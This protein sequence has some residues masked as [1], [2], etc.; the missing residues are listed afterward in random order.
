LYQGLGGA[1]NKNNY[2]NF[3]SFGNNGGIGR[4]GNT[5][6]EPT[7]A[8]GGGGGAGSKGSDFSY[9]TGGGNGGRGKDFVSYFGTNVGHY[10]FFAGGGGGNT[11][12]ITGNRGYGNGGLGLYGGG[13]NGG[14]DGTLEYSADNGLVNTGGGGG[15]GKYDG[16]TSGTLNGGAGGSGYVII[17]YRRYQ[18]QSSSL[19]LVTVKQIPNEIIVSGTTSTTIGSTDRCIIFPYTSDTTGSGQT[20]YTFTTT[21]QL[22]CDILMVAGGGAGGKDTGGGGGGGAVLYGKS[23]NIP[24]GTY[25]IK[26]GK[27]AIAGDVRGKTTEGFG[28]TLLGGGSGTNTTWGDG[29]TVILANSG[30]SGAGGHSAYS[31]STNYAG[32]SIGVSV[33][34]TMLSSATLY[35]GNVGGSGITQGP[36]TRQP[37]SSGGGGGAGSAGDIGTDS[38]TKRGYGGA[39]IFV[40]ILDQVYLWGAGGGGGAYQAPAGDGGLGGGGRGETYAAPVSFGTNGDVGAY[41]Y[42]YS[43]SPINAGNGTGSGGGGAAQGSSVGGS[44]GSGIVIIRYRRVTVNAGYN[45]VNDGGEFKVK[46][47]IDGIDYMRITRDGG[48]IYN[49]TGTPVW[50]TVSDRR[51]KEGIEVASYDRCFESIGGIELYRYS[52]KEGINEL[53]RDKRQ[54]GY[55]AQEVR[56]VLPKAVGEGGEGIL[57]I[58]ITQINYTLYG[59]VKRLMEKYKEK[60]ARLERLE[61]LVGGIG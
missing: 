24:I 7:H 51:I 26:V 32:G 54:L 13:G 30:G 37:V 60:M 41:G 55:I 28:A 36:V 35:S 31:S 1:S 38:G 49:G 2:I 12:F 22:N 29:T 58:D 59:A 33:K 27:G 45:I 8:S 52:Y 34:G 44:G 43:S 15:G 6:S 3:Q 46:S 25:T 42:S 11:G 19:E 20:Q 48:S 18:K 50:S 53:N 47:I 16:T 14:F 21:E 40:N 56:G 4:P 5:G 17:R 23:I 57:S 39:G 61:R 9:I 10:G